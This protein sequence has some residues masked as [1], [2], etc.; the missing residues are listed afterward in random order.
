M[1]KRSVLEVYEYVGEGYS[2]LVLNHDWQT[3][4]LNW[5]PAADASNLNEIER[6]IQS[7]EVFV[8]W[9]GKG[10]IVI[11]EEDG[12][13]MVEAIPGTVYNVPIG[14]WH[15]II[16]DRGSSW[17]IVE[18]RDTHLH[19]TE[20]LPLTENEKQHLHSQLPEWADGRIL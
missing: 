15:T 20:L 17:I 11:M 2:P 7:D 4:I 8:L 10:A 12:L 13:R 9:R 19:D 18:N 3:A 6:H 14:T 5:E 16:G 1:D